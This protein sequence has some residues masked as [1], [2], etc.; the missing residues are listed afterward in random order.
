MPKKIS[1]EIKLQAQELRT[2]GKAYEEISKTL[3]VSISWCRHNLTD[4]EKSKQ[5]VRYVVYIA[6][7]GDT[8]VYVGQGVGHRYKHVNS[9]CS[10]V[11][12]L[13]K[14]HFNKIEYHI[15][16]LLVNDKEF[17]EELEEI[18]IAMFTPK[19]NKRLSYYK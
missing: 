12:E 16:V 7:D 10:H 1:N 2:H 3:N 11:Y 14:D 18:F 17:A 15:E 4:I 6:H 13:N 8:V 9:G 5:P 19:Y